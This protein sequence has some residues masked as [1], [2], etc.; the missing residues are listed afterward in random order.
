MERGRCGKQADDS[1]TGSRSMSMIRSH[2]DPKIDIKRRR[3]VILTIADLNLHRRIALGDILHT[4]DD[5]GHFGGSIWGYGASLDKISVLFLLCR[6]VRVAESSSLDRA[7]LCG[8]KFGG[9]RLPAHFW[10]FA[11]ND[12]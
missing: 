9:S 10:G 2:C 7:D 11:G 6:V 5:L 3:K 12:R 1:A 4:P 8:W